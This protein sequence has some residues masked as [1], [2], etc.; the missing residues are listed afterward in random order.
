MIKQLL[1]SAY[2]CFLL[3]TVYCQTATEWQ[4]DLRQLQQTVHTKYRN[5]FYN[6][7]GNDWDKAVDDL[8]NQ[9]PKL[10]KEQVLAGFVKLVAL[11]HIGHTQMNTF[12]LHQ[13]GNNG[14]SLHR[15][16][17]Q[18]YWFSDGL[19]FLQADSKYANAVP[20]KITR[21]GNM[22]TEAALEAVR[23]LVSY[24][25]EQGYRSNAVFYLAIPEFLLTQGI[26]NTAEE[27]SITYTRNGKEE[28]TVFKAV[29]DNRNFSMTGLET[30]QGWTNAR[31][32]GN[33]PLWL[34]EPSSFRYMEYLPQNKTLYVRHSVTLND[35]DKT[36]AA[37]FNNMADFID[38]NDVERLILDVRTNGGGNN[39][40]N[41]PI[42]TNIIKSTKINQKGKFFCVTGR[43]T[44]SAAQNL[45]NE[46]DRYTEVI[47]VGEPTSE[48]VNFYGDTKTET[49][50]NSKL[51]ASLSWLWWQNMDPRDKR[52]ATYP[53]LAVD[54]SFGDYQNN[55]DPVMNVINAYDK[56]GS[57]EDELRS[58]VEQGKFDEA[59]SKAADYLKDPLH[60]YF[61]NVLEAKI[62]TY[63]YTLINQNKTENA[64]KVFKMNIQ[65][66][67]ESANAYDS[68]AESFMLMGKKE[69]AVKYYEM[70]IAKDK[71]GVTAD[72]SRRQ[73]EKIK[74]GGN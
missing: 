49:L 7:S 72:N 10:N 42:I 57:I 1:L 47:F 27:V 66:F 12:G 53:A 20:G 23:P 13:Q 4:A 5:L 67:P 73:I 21:I 31:T 17:Y 35:G 70:A 40:L 24:E 69:D 45:V 26:T 74:Y 46:L 60:R 38:K 9:I 39:T 2:L 65:L 25:N 29:S 62:N 43:R 16:P 33:T 56:K 3:C 19:Y 68:Y 55:I 50:Q 18:L 14:L 22:R 41:K 44:F 71:E 6:I 54:M 34:K 48:N 28:T 37:F 32:G 52:K 61:K 51:Q 30:P 11:F 63:G 8:N 36:I 15:F 58:F 64:N 59:V